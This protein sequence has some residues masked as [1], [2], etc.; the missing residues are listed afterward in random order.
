MGMGVLV[1]LRALPILQTQ[2]ME[3]ELYLITGVGV[4]S[5]FWQ[6]MVD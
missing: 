3:Q 2:K 1:A 6:E 5:L 4:L